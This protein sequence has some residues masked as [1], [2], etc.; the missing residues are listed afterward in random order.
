MPDAGDSVSPYHNWSVS[1][2]ASSVGQAFGVTRIRQLVYWKNF[3]PHPHSKRKPHFNA[4]N[5]NSYPP[6]TWTS[7]DALIAGAQQR[8]ISVHLNLTGPVPR[9]ATRSKKDNLTRPI[10]REFQAWATAIGR[11][12]A[13]SVDIWSIWNEPNQPDFLK[14]Q[15]SRGKPVSPGLYRRLYQAGVKGLRVANPKDTFL[16]G[17]LSPRGNSQVVFPL[18]F[19]R[20][21]L[22]LN[23][24]YHRTRKCAMLHPS[25]FAHHAYT[26]AKGPRFVPPNRDDVTLGVLSRLTTALD[27]AAR[28]KA[29]PS[30]LPI[31]LTEF[32]VQSFP[33]HIQGVSFPKQAAYL[34]I[35][36]HMAYVNPRVVSFSQYLMRDDRPHAS[37]LNRYAGF[38]SGLRTH[39]GKRKPA[40]RAF[41]LPLAVESYGVSDVL[42][43][44]VRPYRKA[45]TVT[46]QVNPPGKA[47]WRKLKTVKT[48]ATGVYALRATHRDGQ[49]YR[50]RWRSPSGT[51]FQ[52]AEV[53]A[54]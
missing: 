18:D 20:R 7:L 46:I 12:Y 33:D 43:G 9:W 22:C 34:S 41:R 25:G 17:E 37:K 19:F 42:W 35:A 26:T 2:S 39:A 5:P 50:V 16:I 30:H 51:N 29:L 15:Y 52:G 40:Y 14:P 47:G 45:T 31:Y 3:A 53:R 32:G 13:D 36:E 4:S 21:M 6:G 24:S 27:R 8:G 11:R 1:P 44:L 10:P 23:G 38:E 48:T 54:Y 49:R 28:A